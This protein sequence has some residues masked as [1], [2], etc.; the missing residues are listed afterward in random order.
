YMDEKLTA[1][2]NEVAVQMDGIHYGRFDLKCDSI[3]DLK[4][5][6]G[7]MVMEYNG[8]GAE[9]AHIYDPNYPLLN[10]YKDIY[11]HWKIIYLI[12]QKQKKNGVRAMSIREAV[13]RLK[14][15][16]NYQKS[17]NV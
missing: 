17:L 10:K 11:N 2:F 1:V 13:H 7:F 6:K 8:I 4:N 12:Y 16:F 15:Y 9:P 5:G 14:E 3:E